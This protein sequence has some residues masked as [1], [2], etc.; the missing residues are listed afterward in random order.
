M[1]YCN[2]LFLRQAFS[3]TFAM[4]RNVETFFI[5]QNNDQPNTKEKHLSL[6]QHVFGLG[7]SHIGNAYYHPCA[8][9]GS[10][11][12]WSWCFTH[13]QCLLPCLRV[14]R[15][16]MYLVLMLH[17]LAML[18]T[19]LASLGSTCIW[20]WCFPHWQCLLPSLRH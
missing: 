9:L 8:S 6:D 15:I 5:Q 16:N 2:P 4:I 19:I 20:S 10:T 7:A 12:I 13:W 14:I 11:C 18:I 3:E 1:L 17:T